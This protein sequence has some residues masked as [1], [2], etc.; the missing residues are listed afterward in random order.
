[1]TSPDLT[2][3]ATL[4]YSN[5]SSGWKSTMPNVGILKDLLERTR[6]RLLVMNTEDLLFDRD[7]EELLK[8]KLEE[9][10]IEMSAEERAD[11][12][13]NVEETKHYISYTLDV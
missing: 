12:E 1:M 3:M 6:G 7:T 2:A 5:I 8:D 9:Y 11:F 10:R 4:D 13:A